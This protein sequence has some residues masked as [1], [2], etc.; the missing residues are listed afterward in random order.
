MHINLN[1]NLIGG[2]L[3]CVAV[4]LGCYGKDNIQASCLTAWICRIL[5]SSGKHDQYRT[6]WND[7]IG[8]TM[9]RDNL[10][11]YLANFDA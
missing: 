9:F 10:M 11:L 2:S 8:N 4:I 5:T 7:S 3:R 1:I 6:E